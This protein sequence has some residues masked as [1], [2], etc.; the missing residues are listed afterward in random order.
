M[1]E[2]AGTL[3]QGKTVNQKSGSRLILSQKENWQLDELMNLLRDASRCEA[4]PLKYS[5]INAS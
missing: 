1:T 3:V 2:M 4:E 5:P